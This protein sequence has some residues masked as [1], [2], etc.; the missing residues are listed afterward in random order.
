MNFVNGFYAKMMN[1]V[2]GWKNEERGSQTL[3]WIGI[4]AVVVILVGIVST[5]LSGESGIGDKVVEKLK[6]FIDDIGSGS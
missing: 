5:A 1:T 4:A 2:E 6:G 3:E